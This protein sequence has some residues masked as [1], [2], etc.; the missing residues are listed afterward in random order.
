MKEIKFKCKDYHIIKIRT[1]A[2]KYLLDKCEKNGDHLP[3]QHSQRAAI[4]YNFFQDF[5][6]YLTKTTMHDWILNHFGD[7]MDCA[8]E[9][10]QDKFGILTSNAEEDRIFLIPKGQEDVFEWIK[11]NV[12]L[13]YKVVTVLKHIPFKFYHEIGNRRQLS[14]EWTKT[15]IHSKF[16]NDGKE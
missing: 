4:Y 5:F 2:S 11:D 12:G 15:H 6:E 1:Y 16:K 13:P 10:L 7:H 3:K 8:Y 9:E 14:E